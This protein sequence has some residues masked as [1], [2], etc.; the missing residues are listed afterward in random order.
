MFRANHF[1][2]PV[3]VGNPGGLLLAAAMAALALRQDDQL[4]TSTEVH[5]AGATSFRVEHHRGEVARGEKADA[6]ARI[7]RHNGLVARIQAVDTSR[8]GGIGN[9]ATVRRPV[10]E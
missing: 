9:D 8:A 2:R 6:P 1:W 7:A 10:A 3:I 5:F 4:H